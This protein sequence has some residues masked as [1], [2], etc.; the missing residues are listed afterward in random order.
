MALALGLFWQLQDASI[1]I[2][3]VAAILLG[4]SFTGVRNVGQSMALKWVPEEVTAMAM[5]LYTC[6]RYLGGLVGTTA[7]GYF[8]RVKDIALQRLNVY[9]FH[10]TI[11]LYCMDSP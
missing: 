1:G 10:I 2:I 3:S 9:F 4:F 7:V 8:L 11:T 5:G 6:G